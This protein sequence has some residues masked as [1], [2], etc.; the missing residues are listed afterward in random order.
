MSDPQQP[1][2]AGPP[3]I[4]EDLPCPQC[5]YNLR[6]LPASRCPECGT[7]FD[8]EQLRRLYRRGREAPPLRWVL[9][10][11]LRHPVRFWRM[12]PV[13]FTKG[14]GPQQVFTIVAA[15]LYVPTVLGIATT[16][17]SGS[18]LE[19]TYKGV[20]MMVGGIPMVFGGIWLLLLV[21]SALAQVPVTGQ[22]PAGG[23]APVRPF[24]RPGGHLL[25]PDPVVGYAAVWAIP[26][27]TCLFCL[28][29]MGAHYLGYLVHG[30]NL[31]LTLKSVMWVPAF[32][33]LLGVSCV[34]WTAALYQGGWLV[35][36][37]R[38]GPAIW[39]AA[40]NPF[41][42]AVVALLLS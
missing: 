8:P 24:V 11:M 10:N 27:V 14:P 1:Q 16:L 15:V 17:A 23:Q 41:W 21:H 40:S 20:A 28:E 39:Y 30:G 38:K 29:G 22:I 4:S 6:A 9:P 18:P 42:L 35:A 12:P 26:A 31:L 13:Q 3:D 25:V 36:G 37:G 19:S 7:A 32:A 2:T 34:M 33:V 5:G